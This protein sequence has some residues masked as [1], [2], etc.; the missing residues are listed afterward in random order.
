MRPRASKLNCE[1]CIKGL[2]EKIENNLYEIYNIQNYNWRD[3]SQSLRFSAPSIIP[4]MLH[5]YSSLI[6]AI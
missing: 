6:G 2:V 3:F 5:I 4:P 1:L